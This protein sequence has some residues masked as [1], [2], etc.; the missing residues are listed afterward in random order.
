MKRT[1]L[2]IFVRN[3]K[4]FCLSSKHDCRGGE[5]PVQT[6]PEKGSWLDEGE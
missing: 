3:L 1:K 4:Q 2:D 5:G 6:F